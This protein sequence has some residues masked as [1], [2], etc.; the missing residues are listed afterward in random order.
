V[1]FHINILVFIYCDWY[2]LHCLIIYACLFKLVRFI[3]DR[4]QI[5]LKLRCN[6]SEFIL[7]EYSYA[8]NCSFISGLI[9]M[10][11]EYYWFME[12]F[13]KNCYNHCWIDIWYGVLSLIYY[14]CIHMEGYLKFKKLIFFYVHLCANINVNIY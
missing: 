14:Y 12:N 3:C 10:V 2:V 5:L 4:Y 13:L 11:G 6:I 7:R 8:D 9:F 1:V